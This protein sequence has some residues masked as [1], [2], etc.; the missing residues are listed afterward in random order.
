MRWLYQLIA[1]QVD[2]RH[3]CRVLF[4]N[5][6]IYVCWPPYQAYQPQTRT[7]WLKHQDHKALLAECRRHTTCKHDRYAVYRR[8]PCIQ[9]LLNLFAFMALIYTCYCTVFYNKTRHSR[10]LLIISVLKTAA[11]SSTRLRCC[12]GATARVRRQTVVLRQ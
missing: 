10:F 1:T 11:V 5:N 6:I 7:F 2:T 3:Y 9:E 12:G 8:R 4:V